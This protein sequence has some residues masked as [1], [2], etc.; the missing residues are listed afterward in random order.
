MLAAMPALQTTKRRVPG[1]G[2][3]IPR[4]V[5]S[6][7]RAPVLA[8][9]LPWAPGP[10]WVRLNAHA[11]ADSRQ[12][13]CAVFAP[14][15]SIRSRGPGTRGGLEPTSRSANGFCQGDR[16]AVSTSSIPIFGFMTEKSLPYMASRSPA[17]ITALAPQAAVSSPANGNGSVRVSE[18]ATAEVSPFR[19]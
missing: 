1:I 5:E 14:T 18:T 13:S 16:G 12:N 11:T 17:A 9:P 7:P 19:T 8:V 2:G 10:L 15:H 4:T 3:V 6:L